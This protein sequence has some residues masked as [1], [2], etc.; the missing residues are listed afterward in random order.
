MEA[1][2]WFWETNG[3][4]RGCNSSFVTIIPKVADPIGL[5]V[6]RPISLIGCYYKILAKI[7]TERVKKVVGEVVGDVQNAFIKSSGVS[8]ADD[9]IFFGEWS[10]E[11]ARALM[12]ILKCFEEVSGLKVN[13]SKSK[14]YGIG[15]NSCDKDEMALLGKWRWRFKREGDSLWVRVVK[16][17]YKENGGLSSRG[18]VGREFSG[19]E[20]W[21]DIIKVG[22]KIDGVGIDF[23]ST[24][25]CKVG[26]DR[27]VS[28]W[29]DRWIG[30][31]RLCDRFPRLFHLDSRLE[32]RV[33]EKGRWVEGVWRWEWLW[34]REPIGRVSGEMEGLS[35]LLQNVKLSNDCRDQWRWN[36]NEDG[37]FTVKDLT[38][39]VEERTLQVEILRHDTIW[40][41][42]VPK[43][44]NIFVWRALKKR[45]PVREELDKR[46]IDLDT[47]LCPCCDSGVKSCECSLV[48]C[49]MAMGVWEKI[50]SWWNLG[51]VIAFFIRVFFYLN[52]DVNL[53]NNSRLLWQAVLWTSG[54]IIWKKEIIA[55]LRLKSRA[56]I[57]LFK[58]FNL[59][60][61]IG[62]REGRKRILSIGNSGCGILGN[63]AL[64]TEFW[65]RLFGA[66]MPFATGNGEV[67]LLC[68]NKLLL[69]F[70]L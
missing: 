37:G 19:G 41:K 69:L 42:L 13:F 7:L 15:V 66:G 70:L 39:M 55:C 49:N 2:N 22:R 18:D 4:S 62:L 31:F 35:G 6:S 38:R 63:V 12:C 3:I 61:L 58:I 11:N 48:L 32:G 65:C 59:K 8:F 60:V 14:L 56:L 36:L 17:I 26:N 46:G 51:G 33:V 24:F 27:D 1:V 52:G 9:T 23:T 50:H 21:R 57:K 28:F 25:M 10:K 47:V 45:L 44:V 67:E 64:S 40:N 53:P 43:K 68:Q 16:S 30:D 20:V 29:L 34:T 5:G 54:Y